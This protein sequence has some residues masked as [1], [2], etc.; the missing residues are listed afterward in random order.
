MSEWS[1]EHAWKVCVRKRT[2]GSNPSLTA[3]T[4]RTPFLEGCQRLP[5]TQA[6]RD[7]WQFRHIW[8]VTFFDEISLKAAF[9]QY[10]S[11]GI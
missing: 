1:K 6:P 4:F 8:P 9:F 10:G 7:L 3:I 2:E 5:E 11:V